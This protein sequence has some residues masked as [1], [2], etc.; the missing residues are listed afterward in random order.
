MKSPSPRILVLPL[1]LFV[2]IFVCAACG[3]EHEVQK[4]EAGLVSAAQDALVIG[5]DSPMHPEADKERPALEEANEEQSVA[6]DMSTVASTTNEAVT[7]QSASVVDPTTAPIEAAPASKPSGVERNVK[8]PSEDITEA[9][10]PSTITISIT[11]DEK[12][13]V[14]LE[15]TSIQL[16]DGDSVLDVL[17]R[18]TKSNKI[19]LEYKGAGMLSYVEGIAN[20]YEFD[21]GTNSGWLF[22]INGKYA[23]R[24]A[25]AIKLNIG[26][27]VEWI[28]SIKKDEELDE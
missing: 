28:Y 13:G 10:A 2:L 21:E 12:K 18:V 27:N 22:K 8:M 17:K 9:T 24:S 3:N 14:I 11:S 6:Q 15:P 5:I 4:D 26:D 16:E 25:G 7:K 23:T 20:V 19:P 1:L